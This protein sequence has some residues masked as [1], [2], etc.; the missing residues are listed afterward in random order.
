[1]VTRKPVL[2]LGVNSEGMGHATRAHVLL[3]SLA[4]RFDVHVF[5]GGRAHAYLAA[6]FPRVHRVWFGQ[7]RYRDNRADVVSTVI[8]CVLQGPLV[9]LSGAWV[10]LMALWLR[11]VAVL[12]D[13]ESLTAWAG[14][15]TF[16]PVIT[17]DNQGLLQHGTLPEVGPE[18]EGAARVAR[19]LM[20]ATAPVVHHALVQ[21]FHT[22]GLK[23][24][25]AAATLVPPLVR[26]QVLCWRGRTR[27]DGPVLVYQTS[28]SN[29]ALLS[30][31]REATQRTALTFVVYGAGP[32]GGDARVRCAA[33]SDEEFVRDLAHAPFV[34]VNGGHSTL[35][36]ALALNKP[37]LAE[38]VGNHFEQAVNVACM[39][40]LGVGRGTRRL[41]V[42]DVM[43]FQRDLP[44][45]TATASRLEVVDNR[46]LVEALEA[47]LRG[48][49]P[50]VAQAVPQTEELAA[51]VDHG[52]GD[53]AGEQR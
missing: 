42:Q 37:V 18:H 40:A 24:A 38:P 43:D 17:V 48:L 50:S 27:T 1:M 25:R 41:T 13:F 10:T 34:M 29:H 3:E 49:S 46:V 45:L 16:T 52:H 47:V 39:E 9:L 15:L 28:T 30:T 19:R 26:E 2:F 33:F 14:M 35:S 7:L 6:R 23:D 21:T 51:Q 53:E 20:R 32:P 36:E 12:S 44:A 8:R 11:P 5:C 4:H 31:L 22:G